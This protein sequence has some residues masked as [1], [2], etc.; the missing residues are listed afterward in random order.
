MI[1]EGL[2]AAL[3]SGQEASRTKLGWRVTGDVQL[4]GDPQ[5]KLE[6]AAEII[7]ISSGFEIAPNPLRRSWKRLVEN[8]VSGLS[9]LVCFWSWMKREA[10]NGWT[11][12]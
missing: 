11:D 7:F 6:H 9:F 4:V 2:P 12:G 10:E 1:Q 8:R 3:A 5:V